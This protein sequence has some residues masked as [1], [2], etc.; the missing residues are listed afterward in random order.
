MIVPFP[1]QTT[2][3][4][5]VQFDN[6]EFIGQFPDF[7]N[8]TSGQNQIAFNLAQY[9]LENDANSLVQDANARQVFLYL[10]T[11]HLAFLLFGTAPATGPAT[12]PP[13]A[14]SVGRA[15]EMRQGSVDVKKTLG[16]LEAS[17]SQD[18]FS[19]TKYGSMFWQMSLPY[20]Q[21]TAV[22]N[23]SG[24]NFVGLLP[25]FAP[26]WVSYW[27]LGGLGTLGIPTADF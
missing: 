21:A 12:P 24:P 9:L 6:T 2:V 13:A 10:I 16:K 22:L 17:F 26:G 5:L 3:T 4:G 14:N 11:A 27:G 8:L 20:R 1:A 23:Q 15:V 19:Q 18:F 25:P 7:T